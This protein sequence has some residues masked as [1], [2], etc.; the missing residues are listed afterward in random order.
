MG[1][2]PTPIRWQFSGNRLSFERLN[3][4]GASF[5]AVKSPDAPKMTRIVGGGLL[6]PEVKNYNF[7]SPNKYSLC[8][9]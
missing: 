8:S 9:F 3:I 5:L 4:A 7:E 2:L 6:I 1:V